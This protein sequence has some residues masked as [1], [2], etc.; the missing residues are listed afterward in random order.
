[1]TR[2][3]S[4]FVN[5]P[6]RLIRLT[7][8]HALAIL[9]WRYPHPYDFY[10]P[11]EDGP[12]EQF[13]VE[14]L[15]PTLNFHAVLDTDDTFLGFCSFG[16][17]GQVPGGDYADDALDIGLGMRPELTGQG[18]GARFVQSILSYAKASIAPNCFRM[19]VAN[20]NHR[21]MRLYKQL[22]FQELA[23]FDDIRF[24]LPYTILIREA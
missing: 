12:R 16:L 11:P 20:F 22:G 18:H 6:W 13:I 7:R 4:R 19:T 10:D 8:D 17:D 24:G 2:T 21:A 23:G 3:R 9:D 15:K 1:M 14:F 5:E